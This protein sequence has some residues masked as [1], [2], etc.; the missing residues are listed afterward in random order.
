VY[1]LRSDNGSLT[2]KTALILV[3]RNGFRSVTI[4]VRRWRFLYWTGTEVML[5]AVELIITLLLGF[6]LGRIWQIRQQI[7][8]A[9][10]VQ[11]RSYKSAPANKEPSPAT[12]LSLQGNARPISPASTKRQGSALRRLPNAA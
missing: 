4:S 2:T 10:Q 12:T 1:Q 5:L 11:R 3:A 6:V 9:E 8:F 7:L